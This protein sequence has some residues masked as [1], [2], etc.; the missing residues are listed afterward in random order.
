MT[1]ATIAQRAREAAAFVQDAIGEAPRVAIVLGSGLSDFSKNLTQ[2]VTVE[3]TGIPHF[4]EPTVPGHVGEL[5]AGRVNGLPVLTARGRFHYY[6]G[7]DLDMLSLPVRLFA[8]LGVSTV[9]ITNAAGCVNAAWNE[10]DLML[11]TGHLDCTY[12]TSSDD[13]RLVSGQE[14]YATEAL[15]V[16]REAALKSGISL[17]QGTY[18]WNL[19]PTFETPAEI[20][21]IRSL[22][23]DAVG[24]ST[25]P[26]I[27]TAAGLGLQVIGISCLTNYAAGML[28]KPLNH[29]E[30]LEMGQRVQVT[31]AKLVMEILEGLAE[32]QSDGRQH[33]D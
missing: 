18:A 7:H 8:A 15:N 32:G 20:R 1:E 6:E 33:H 23:G 24:M 16:A 21:H 28:D 11:I 22:G 3:Y 13:P 2:A 30:V 26:E 10:G 5:V 29:D 27:E 31:F 9:I 12:I 4:P 25:V 14:M 19:G 17:R